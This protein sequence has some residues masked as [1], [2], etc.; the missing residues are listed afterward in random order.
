MRWFHKSK[1]T[2]QDEINELAAMRKGGEQ[3]HLTFINR[4]WDSVL[5][6]LSHRLRG[7]SAIEQVKKD[8]FQEGWIT[9]LEKALTNPDFV[10]YRADALENYL[11]SLSLGHARNLL[12]K[13]RSLLPYEMDA[14]L[15]QEDAGHMQ[16]EEDIPDH[17]LDQY[18]RKEAREVWEKRINSLSEKCQEILTKFYFEYK[19]LKEIGN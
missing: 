19:T 12:K 14:F 8:A 18:L 4:V 1:R 11:F 9:F 13:G 17:P 15:E 7:F 5:R 10:P 2:L 6:R 16:P 3:A